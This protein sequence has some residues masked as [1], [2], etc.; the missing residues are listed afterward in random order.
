[1]EHGIAGLAGRTRMMIENW[2]RGISG[3]G[4]KP[5]S[6]RD[7]EARSLGKLLES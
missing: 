6:L 7:T 4:L 3:I 1:M 5:V 2:S